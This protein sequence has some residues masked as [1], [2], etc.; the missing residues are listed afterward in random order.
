[1]EE[2]RES[3]DKRYYSEMLLRQHPWLK[4]ALEEEEYPIA[5]SYRK[6]ENLLGLSLIFIGSFAVIDTLVHLTALDSIGVG[7]LIILA[8]AALL[9]GGFWAIYFA[10]RSYVLVTAERVLYQKINLIGRPGKTVSIPRS[11]IKRARF[12]KSTV[13]YLAKRGDGG[14]SILMKNGK[15]VF[16][17]SVVSGENILG[18]LQ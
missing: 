8:G 12:L 13:M 2:K 10:K 17:S 4:D 18:A 15:T 3:Q 5:F 14:I 6:P 1:M 9:Y 7:I 16:I 11:E